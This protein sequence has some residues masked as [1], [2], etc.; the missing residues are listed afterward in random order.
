MRHQESFHSE[1]QTTLWYE[2][3]LEYIMSGIN[4]NCSKVVRLERTTNI[5]WCLSLSQKSNDYYP[6]YVRSLFLTSG[7]LDRDKY[8]GGVGMCII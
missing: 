2:I 5:Q 3:Y 4:D 6:F 8:V 1:N 7:I